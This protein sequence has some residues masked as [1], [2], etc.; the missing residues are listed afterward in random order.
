[1]F[2]DGGTLY[3]EKRPDHPCLNIGIVIAGGE[4][5]T[6]GLPVVNIGIGSY[7]TFI[8]VS[9]QVLFSHTYNLQ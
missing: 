8:I 6:V 1:M 3:R 2:L 9:N 7:T 5:K 4:T